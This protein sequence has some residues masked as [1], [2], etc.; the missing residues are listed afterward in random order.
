MSLARQLRALCA[1]AL[2]SAPCLA[3]GPRPAHLDLDVML[4]PESRELRGTAA[5]QAKADPRVILHQSLAIHAV[6][7]NGTERGVPA[8]RRVGDMHEWR[9]EAP[10][11]A[12]LRVEYAGTLPPLDLAL[13]HRRVLR[14]L[15][16]MAGREGSFL[17]ASARWHPRPAQ[18]FTY[19]VKLSL[20][21]DQ[22]GIVPGRLIAEK[23]PRGDEERYSAS[24]DF[25]HPV[26][27]IDLMAGPYVVR[28]RIVQRDGAKPLRLRTYFGRDS[29]PL[30][31]AYLDD[32]RRYIELYSGIIGAYPYTEF[33]VVASPLPTG[34]GKPTL[35]YIGAQVLKLPFI[36]ATSLGHEVLHNWWGNGV[37]PDYAS[38]NWSEGLTAF[39]ADYFYKERESSAAAR[40]M[41]LAWLRDF[42]VV[43]P[44]AHRPLATFR[45]RTHGAEAIAG[46]GKAAM[47][48][49]MLRDLIGEDAFNRGIRVFWSRHRFRTASWDDLRHAFEASSGRTLQAY[50]GQWI[51]RPGGPRPAIVAARAE[52]HRG[53]RR[54]VL[55]FRQDEPAYALRV[56]VELVSVKGRQ[57]R[58]I[59]I[60]RASETVALTLDAV[61]E[62]VRLDPE[63]RL[64]RVLE[65][66]Q[67]PP[68]LRQWIIAAAPRLVVASS[69]ADVEAA[70]MA[71]AR[72]L[73]E[74]PARRVSNAE[75]AT[76]VDPLLLIGPHGEIDAAL[77]MLKL[78][79]RPATIEGLGSAQVWTI[80]DG[81]QARPPVAVISVRDAESLAAL[82][83]PLPHYGAQ[84][85]LAFDGSRA[86]ERGV[87]A[88]P[89]R[90]IPV[91][92]S[93]PGG[94]A[95]E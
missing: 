13:D 74:S 65:R 16:P 12:A 35:T 56:P 5:W 77:A 70:A 40:E 37:Y 51:E 52:R 67:L 4:N 88:A 7:V 3:A 92:P 78:P 6:V 80:R 31:D 14:S 22:R 45:S 50:F 86:I 1:C 55:E 24:F 63:L 71:L 62:G 83:R 10:A 49:L 54:L 72:R 42:A 89:G 75:A 94:P 79:P 43:P 69:D 33:S 47:V 58:W 44:G 84:S 15:P 30:A 87:W 85:Y 38:G 23:V 28:E 26:D 73:F 20:P 64:W 2:V 57:M 19:R 90:M 60:G 34:F 91:T 25:E 21:G 27:G 95:P 53:A 17:P 81:R 61:P 93:S 66:E 41:R 11:G 48:F 9:I 8:S 39:M 29:D 18:P 82:L 36:R 59:D 76:G 46:Y 32:S 68:I